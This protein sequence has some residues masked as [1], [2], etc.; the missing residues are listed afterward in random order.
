MDIQ[1]QGRKG[2]MNWEMRFDINTLPCVK[3]IGRGK[4]PNGT[5]GPAQGSV[6]T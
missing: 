6:V 2:G 3:E 1:T 5:G 4:L